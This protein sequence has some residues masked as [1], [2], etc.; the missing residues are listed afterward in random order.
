VLIVALDDAAW[1]CAM[2]ACGLAHELPELEV[3]PRLG[4]SANQ[5]TREDGAEGYRCTIVSGR[6]AG[7]R[8]DFWRLSS[9]VIEFATFSVIRLVRSSC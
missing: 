2:V 7:S 5:L 4:P 6:G 1:V 3:Q 8:V 9:G